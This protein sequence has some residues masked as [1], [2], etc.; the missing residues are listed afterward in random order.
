[1]LRNPVD[2]A[3]SQYWMSVRRGFEDLPF[4]EA[5]RIERNRIQRDDFSFNHFS[6]IERGRYA[7][8]VKQFLKYF[9]M[10][11]MRFIIFETDFLKDS[12]ATVQDLVQWIGVSIIPLRLGI[13]S[14]S[15]TMFHS[16]F[17]TKFVH[18]TNAVRKIGKLLIPF[19]SVRRKI[20]LA[21]DKWNQVPL[22]KPELTKKERAYVYNSFFKSE[23]SELEAV[24]G[25][26]LD[27]W[28]E[29]D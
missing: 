26:S 9:Q 5:L 22:V 21:M 12:E 24:I 1:M 7:T 2:R 10:E 8:L 11:N 14:N 13:Q 15:A 20:M 29:I 17:V 27:H 3:Y 18:Q 23:I 19:Q 28:R 4:M 16:H 25:R 6:Y